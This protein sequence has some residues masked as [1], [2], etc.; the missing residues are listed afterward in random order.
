MLTY[1]NQTGQP[2]TVF[3]AI[4]HFCGRD[5]VRFRVV[6]FP[7]C[8]RQSLTFDLA[9]FTGPQVYGHSAAAGVAAV[10]AVSFPDATGSGTGVHVEPFSAKGGDI[11]IFFDG[12]G[13]PLPGGLVT[14]FKPELS[15]PDG[16]N[17]TFFGL[18]SPLDSDTFPNFFGTSAAAPHAAAVAALLRNAVPSISPSKITSTLRATAR[19]IEMPG[20]DELSGDGL[21]D[22][23]AALDALLSEPTPTATPIP[24]PGDCNGDGHVTIDELIVAVRIALDAAPIASC[25]GV[26]RNADGIVAIDELITAVRAA[27]V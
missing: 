27:L 13:Q 14:R 25:P 2:Q 3:I 17:T 18:D 19:D 6:T 5:D 4:D 23:Y 9:I 16:V 22:A 12:R 20:R 8:S 7:T 10:A 21:I 26:D 15:G 11:P 1:N 24:T